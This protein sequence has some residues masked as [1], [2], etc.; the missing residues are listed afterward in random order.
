MCVKTGE[1][2]NEKFSGLAGSKS[3][4]MIYGWVVVIELYGRWQYV[5]DYPW[6]LCWVLE[7]SIRVAV[8]VIMGRTSINCISTY[9]SRMIHPML[10]RN[11]K[12]GKWFNESITQSRISS[13]RVHSIA[14]EINIKWKPKNQFKI[15]FDS[16]S[17]PAQRN[18]FTMRKK[19]NNWKKY[20]LKMF[21]KQCADEDVARIHN[22]KWIFIH[23]TKHQINS[24]KY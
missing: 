10:D 16:L 19:K 1:A 24:T 13:G 8:S 22:A 15:Q 12:N 9:V 18:D 3:K 2:K 5:I 21:N 7:W 23:Q 14:C 6:L 17:S 4:G 20:G 11:R